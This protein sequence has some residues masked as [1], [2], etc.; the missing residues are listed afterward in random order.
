MFISR[1]VR[2]LSGWVRVRGSSSSPLRWSGLSRSEQAEAR[3]MLLPAPPVWA[4]RSSNVT[5]DPDTPY[6]PS[7][8]QLAK[9]RRRN[10]GGT[11]ARLVKADAGKRRQRARQMRD[12]GDDP[13][14]ERQEH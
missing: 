2:L 14:A 3:P 11:L 5:D 8:S 13:G 7:L 12:R 9:T 1:S 10:G 4:L 6:D